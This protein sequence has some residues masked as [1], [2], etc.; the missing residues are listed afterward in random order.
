MMKASA[1]VI[2]RKTTFTVGLVIIGTK[3]RDWVAPVANL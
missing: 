1:T 2:A 3:P